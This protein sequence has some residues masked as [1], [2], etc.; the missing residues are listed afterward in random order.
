MNRLSIPLIIVA[1]SVCAAI[2]TVLAFQWLNR[3]K[4]IATDEVM[5]SPL[6]PVREASL[7]SLPQVID[8]RAPAKRVMKSVVS[9]DTS[10]QGLTWRG[11]SV[12][13]PMGEGSGVVISAS[14]YI[15]TNNHVIAGAD[16]IQVQ[17]S[18]GRSLRA[19]LV[20][21]DPRS[22]LAVL[23]V[24]APNLTP[25][26]IGSSSSL[27]VG[28]WVIAVGNP[29]GYQNTV[30][31]GVVSSLDR[32]LP[33]SGQSLLVQAIQTD[34][35]INQ[36][37]SGGALSNARGQLVGINT[38]IAT[39]SGGSVGIGFAIPIDRARR[40]VDDI[41]AYGRVRYGVMG[42]ELFPRSGLLR[43]ERV[44]A[45]LA[46]LT[47]AEPPQDGLLVQRVARGAPAA[48]AGIGQYDVLLKLDGK[49]V[50]EWIEFIR[51]MMDK[52]P[53]DTIKVDYWS[54]GKTKSATIKL[55]DSDAP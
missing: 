53:G 44:R 40:V 31:V 43:N 13:Q 27:E 25:I 32:T 1:S 21:T 24:D 2:G 45:E 4:P 48:N 19:K 30:S 22:D 47:Q 3:E 37:N 55:Q 46:S 36:G 26:E 29:L 23:K 33:T 41:I 50:K 12:I 39:N 38:A 11:D 28:E 6:V 18:D 49:P 51:I 20:G 17:L 52:R 42:I 5:R 14:G 10:R 34:A 35:A 8:F 16:F 54:R 7:E 9:V 15:V